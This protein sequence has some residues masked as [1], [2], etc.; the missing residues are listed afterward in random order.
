MKYNHELIVPDEGL[1]FKMFIFEGKD[2]NY[3]REMHWHRSVEIFAV[4]EGELC[5][6][7]KEKPYPLVQGEFMIVNSNEVHSVHSP[8]R[9]R[10]LYCRYRSGCLRIILREKDS[11]GSHTIRWI[12]MNG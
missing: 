6:Y 2:G 5:F 4:C 3:K 12:G 10:R 8:K 11:S 9:T 7:I 1:P